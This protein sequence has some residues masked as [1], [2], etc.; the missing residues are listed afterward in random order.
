MSP[1]SMDIPDIND[2]QRRG[3][4]VDVVSAWLAQQ[5][6]LPDRNDDMWAMETFQGEHQVDHFHYR[7][8]PD[9]EHSSSHGNKLGHRRSVS[10]IHRNGPSMS[11]LHSRHRS[12]VSFCLN[13]EEQELQWYKERYQE[14]HLQANSPH[15][16]HHYTIHH[17]HYQS[18]PLHQD[19]FQ[20][21]YVYQQQHQYPYQYH[22]QYQYQQSGYFE[23]LE[24]D[25]LQDG[26]GFGQVQGW[27]PLGLDSIRRRSANELAWDRHLYYQEQ[28]FKDEVEAERRKIEERRQRQQYWEYQQ[29]HYAAQRQL[30]MEQESQQMEHH[31]AQQDQHTLP[32]LTIQGEPCLVTED[33]EVVAR[34]GSLNRLR[35]TSLS[36]D[37]ARVLG[38]CRSTTLSAFGTKRGSDKAKGFCGR[39]TT[40]PSHELDQK[41]NHVFTS[42]TT[43]RV[44]SSVRRRTNGSEP[45]AH[46]RMLSHDSSGIDLLRNRVESPLSSFFPFVGPA[47]SLTSSPSPS[48]EPRLNSPVQLQDKYPSAPASAPATLS[49]KKTIKDL[50]PAL[51]SLARRCSTRF[52]RPNSVDGASFFGMTLEQLQQQQ[53]QA[54]DRPGRAS[55]STQSDHMNDFKPLALGPDSL[56]EQRQMERL[57]AESASLTSTPPA[58]ATTVVFL[59]IPFASK[60]AVTRSGER[61]TVHRKVTLSRPNTPSRRPKL[62]ASASM[63][64]GLNVVPS[65][66]SSLDAKNTSKREGSESRKRH[67][68]RFANGRGIDY[69]FESLDHTDGSNGQRQQHSRSKSEVVTMIRAPVN[70]GL[71][72]EQGAAGDGH[73]NDDGDHNEDDDHDECIDE[74]ELAILAGGNS[75]KTTAEPMVIQVT[76]EHGRPSKAQLAIQREIV[77]LLAKGVRP[78]SVAASGSLSL[79]KGTATSTLALASSTEGQA[80]E[81]TVPPPVLSPLEV[82]AQEDVPP[83]PEPTT[84]SPSASEC[85]ADDLPH[86]LLT[87]SDLY[88]RIAFMLVPRYKYRYQPLVAQ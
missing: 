15:Y 67:S 23:Q 64:Q 2:R 14:H 39:R 30:Q 11:H 1:T 18:L 4:K 73:G 80:A 51:R 9:Q 77:S 20:S 48:F 60:S 36:K 46:R 83:P 53:Q 65:E 7:I 69:F 22:D 74:A 6:T 3:S 31:L 35:P 8:I 33:G 41:A 13:Q 84:P 10:L 52:S 56:A 72:S 68:M 45:S 76:D 5:H 37:T 21:P 61:P 25:P 85:N 54:M 27:E 75:D 55:T 81:Q 43:K 40:S 16:P 71:E 34:T 32:R 62:M 88:E 38:L 19:Y 12:E 28:Q 26:Y 17:S 59:P 57:A 70:L 47:R 63:P 42:S 49:R 50:A 87:E 24:N 79:N 78:L 86:F 58:G 82:E 66:G 44:S 29:E